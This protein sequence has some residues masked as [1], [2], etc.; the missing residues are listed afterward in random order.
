MTEHIG[1]YLHVFVF[2]LL[3]GGDAIG[4]VKVDELWREVDS[5]GQPVEPFNKNHLRKH[6]V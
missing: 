6:E 5:C 3:T 2:D 4:D 1:L